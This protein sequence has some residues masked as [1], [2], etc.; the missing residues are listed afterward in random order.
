MKHFSNIFFAIAAV[1]TIVFAFMLLWQKQQNEH[2]EKI[3]VQLT[4]TQNEEL[5]VIQ[6]EK[7][8]GQK[9]KDGVQS[10]LAYIVGIFTR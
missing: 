5:P 1:L 9:I 8:K 10:T 3:V 2:T 6:K 4:E 7:T